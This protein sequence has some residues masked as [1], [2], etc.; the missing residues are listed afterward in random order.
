MKIVILD[1]H[2]SNPGD[3]AWSRL[4]ELG[5]LEIYERST[6][7][8]VLERV[9]DAEIVLTNKCRIDHEVLDAAE[10]LK[11][12]GM[13]STGFD[14]LDLPSIKERGI[15]A[16]NIPA[17]STRAVAQM[18]FAHILEHFSRVCEYNASVQA[19]DWANAKDFT[20]YLKTTRDLADKTISII[21]FGDIGRAVARIAL[22]FGMKVRATKSSRTLESD[23]EG[24]VEVLNY[25]EIFK[26]DIVSL[27]CPLNETSR[28]LIN[29]D[30]LKEFKDGAI[31]INTARGAL[32]DDN[33]V[34]EALKSGKLAGCGLDVMT[35]EPIAEDSV[36][37]GLE[38]CFITPHIA[39]ASFES[40]RR[41]IEL[42]HENIQ[43]FLTGKR[44]NRLD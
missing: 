21:G 13:L 2:S 5:E 30:S 44:L 33:A 26:S 17:Y 37:L 15:A 18:T 12:V 6:R 28:N 25:P 9:R 23:L 43:A 20:Y 10:K 8:E 11:Y 38:N 29:E 36:L 14:V 40:R 41:L 1:A 31:L 27:H 22:A 3:L 32:I 39:W 24:K 4:A 35:S 7:A 19:G 42:A 34:A 16:T